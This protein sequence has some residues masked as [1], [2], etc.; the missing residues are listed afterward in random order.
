MASVVHTGSFATIGEAYDAIAKW[1]D[2]NGYQIIGPP[3]E[4]NLKLPEKLGDQNAPNT[5]NEIQFP[6]KKM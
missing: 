3:R 4:L 5:V 2:G 6:V 1:I